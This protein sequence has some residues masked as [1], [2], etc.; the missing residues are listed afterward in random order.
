M[1]I[2][3]SVR[4]V[5]GPVNVS[6]IGKLRSSGRS[7]S[8]STVPHSRHAQLSNGTEGAADPSI[9]FTRGGSGLGV[10]TCTGPSLG[11]WSSPSLAGAAAPV[12]GEAGVPGELAWLVPPLSGIEARQLFVERAQAVLPSF[13]LND[14][15][16]AIDEICRRLDHLPL[17]IELAAARVPVLPP[18]KIAERLDE[19]FKLLTKGSRTSLPRHRTLR[20]TMEWSY[21]LLSERERFCPFTL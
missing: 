13:A 6:P 5:A 16:G 15:A 14:A 19:A 21:G 8:T 1:N 7:Q 17:A 18:D 11:R 4:W 3:T 2:S 20:A 12:V 10:D 9:A